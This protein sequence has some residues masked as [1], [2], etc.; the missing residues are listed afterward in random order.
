MDSSKREAYHAGSWYSG[1]GTELNK[2]LDGW[3]QK[4][5]LEIQ[6]I[7]TVKAVI[8]PHA[9]Y[10]YCGPTAGWAYKYFQYAP[11]QDPLRV[12]LLGPCHHT[13]IKG[14][15][16]S[17][18]KFYETPIGDIELD[19]ETIDKLKEEGKF[20]YTNKAT[21]EEEHS[22][23]MHLPYIRKAFEGRKIK[24]VPIMV[25]GLDTS[26]EKY[27]G[28]LLAKYFDDEN[29]VFCVS[30]D[31]C[32]W[33]SRFDFTYYKKEDGKIYQ[34]IEKLDKEGMSLIE[35][36]DVKGFASY[37][38]KTDN[39]ICGR[40]PIGVL[41]NTIAASKYA[42]KLVTKFVQY[43]QSSQV[44]RADDSSVSYA[45]SVTYLTE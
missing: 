34:S 29:T 37:L 3:L 38:D 10:S 25:G 31:F 8:G 42:G 27:Y 40:H 20:I 43:A 16:L 35:K 12:F 21:E 41:L 9:G 11:S 24:L 15:G 1:K 28:E 33:G 18:L 45:S 39:T 26:A 32:H 30:S 14:C 7:K 44:T 2:Q 17:K 4:A 22:L 23:E 36:H 6:G 13:Y 19:N 5:Q